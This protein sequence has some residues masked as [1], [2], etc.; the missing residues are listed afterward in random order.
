MKKE[1]I[2]LW[3]EDKYDIEYLVDKSCREGLTAEEEE[4]LD[5]LMKANKMR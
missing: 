1:I 5:A 4:E 2:P 3:E